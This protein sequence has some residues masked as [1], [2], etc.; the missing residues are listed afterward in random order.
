MNWKQYEKFVYQEL[1]E[2]L[3]G[4]RVSMD[5]RIRGTLSGIDRQID[6]LVEESM[7]SRNFKQA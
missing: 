5:Q 4:A 1:T 6:I 3:H 2:K 7:G